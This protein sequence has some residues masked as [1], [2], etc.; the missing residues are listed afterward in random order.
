VS[1]SRNV[2]LAWGEGILYSI[3]WALLGAVPKYCVIVTW[4]DCLCV[5]NVVTLQEKTVVTTADRPLSL[6][7]V[8]RRKKKAFTQSQFLFHLSLFFT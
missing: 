2:S 4:N 8:P 5:Q 6:F 3:L 1:L 7:Y